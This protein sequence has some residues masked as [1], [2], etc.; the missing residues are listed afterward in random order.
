ML[1]PH[2]RVAA[3]QQPTPRNLACTRPTALAYASTACARAQSRLFWRGRNRREWDS[4]LDPNYYRLNRYH[5]LKNKAKLIASVKRRSKLH[6]DN[7][8]KPFFSPKHARWASHWGQRPPG[9][10]YRYENDDPA[11]VEESVENRRKGIELELSSREKAWKD[12]MERMR[13]RVEQDPYEAVFGKRFEPFWSPL[14][15]SWMREEMGLKATKQAGNLS[16]TTVSPQNKPKSTVVASADKQSKQPHKAAVLEGKLDSSVNQP[17]TY[18]FAST[19]AYDSW[20]Q[21]ARRTD[22]DSDSNK[23]REFEYDPVS[24]RMVPVDAP[25]ESKPFPSTL[26]P[27]GPPPSKSTGAVTKMPVEQPDAT[28]APVPTYTVQSQS[29]KN[30]DVIASP[31]KADM[32]STPRSFNKPSALAK[33]PAQDID[34]MTPDSVRASMGKT[35]PTTSSGSNKQDLQQSFDS[36]SQKHDSLNESYRGRGAVL[37]AK[38]MWDQAELVWQYE[39]ELRSLKVRKNKVLQDSQQVHRHKG[40]LGRIDQ[41]TQQLKSL[42]DSLEN[43]SRLAKDNSELVKTQEFYYS[44]KAS[45]REAAKK[46]ASQEPRLETSLERTRPELAKSAVNHASSQPLGLA[47]ERMQ[48]RSSRKLV[49]DLDDSAAH[50]STESIQA[51]SSV[52][53]E[54]RKQADILQAD[55]VK[56]TAGNPPRPLTGWA[57]GMETKREK[58][59]QDAERITK[60]EK[61]NAKLQAEVDALKAAYAHRDDRH[62]HKCSP[63]DQSQTVPQKV[64]NAGSQQELKELQ[65]EGDW[66]P[67]I[68]R[69]ADSSMWYKQPAVT[70]QSAKGEIEKATQQAR[71][72]QLVNEVRDIYEKRFG[73]IDIGHRQPFASPPTQAN[74]VKERSAP[75]NKSIGISEDGKLG[76][77]LARHEAPETYRFKDDNLEATIAGKYVETVGDRTVEQAFERN[78]TPGTY[79]FKDDNLKETLAAKEREMERKRTIMQPEPASKVREV[80]AEDLQEHCYGASSIPQ[81]DEGLDEHSYSASTQDNKLVDDKLPKLIPTNTRKTSVASGPAKSASAKAQ[82][83]SVEWEEPPV[84]K[85]LAYDSGN[86]M[87]STATTTSNFTGSETPISIPQALSQLYQPARFVPHFASLQKEGYQVIHGTKD[88]LVFKLVKSTA[89]ATPP[90]KAQDTQSIVSTSPGATAVRDHARVNPID[91]TSYSRPVAEPSTGNFASPTG[92]VNHDPVIAEDSQNRSATSDLG[93]HYDYGNQY[94]PTTTNEPSTSPEDLDNSRNPR[95]K[96]EEPVFSGS[97]RKWNGRQSRSQRKSEARHRENRHRAFKWTLSVAAGTVGLTYIV[98]VAAE[99]AR[100]DS[101]ARGIGRKVLAGEKWEEIAAAARRE[102]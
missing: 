52:P 77:E 17:R 82:T 6:W 58:H 83:E 22:W 25:A 69:W 44:Q 46:A 89:S 70:P 47:H 27:D 102:G 90:T 23:V 81:P 80:P 16:N 100:R 8:V 65:G 35:K 14:V 1:P 99:G 64:Q 4:T 85:V 11:R 73:T 12:Q 53:R 66:C 59:T 60:E 62:A 51:K 10:R 15:P 24:N 18:S 48:P 28:K 13:K 75:N 40:E 54:W 72:Q 56:R 3:R 50:E 84:Y 71:D 32:L 41:R 63:S 93:R 68:T 49:D 95:V 34:F 39:N 20:T 96:R 9:A 74:I 79:R 29:A 2:L 67:N 37:S 87:F 55:R 101:Q 26:D 5:T 7:G 42:I 97:G 36:N 21:R 94:S 30:A 78:E 19:T 33:L 88:L 91:G 98:G 43:N 45:K 61:A 38:K 31:E 86:D 92:F 76:D 57:E